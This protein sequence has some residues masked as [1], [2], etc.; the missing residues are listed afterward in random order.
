[1][2][3]YRTF[4]ANCPKLEKTLKRA[5]K[6]NLQGVFLLRLFGAFFRNF[7]EILKKGLDVRAA[8][9]YTIIVTLVCARGLPQLGVMSGEHIRFSFCIHAIG[10]AMPFRAKPRSW[11]F[12]IFCERY[13][14][15]FNSPLTN[16]I[17]CVIMKL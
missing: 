3:K 7:D 8:V 15:L 5:Y 12:L 16:A 11:R 13:H 17:Y 6:A 14:I 4:G 1:M 2:M 10:R 9:C